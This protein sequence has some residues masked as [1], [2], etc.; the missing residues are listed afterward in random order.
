MDTRVI[1]YLS[2]PFL[3]ELLTDVREAGKMKAASIDIT[4][5]CNLRC[6]GCYFFSDG[7]DRYKSPKDDVLFDQL[8]ETEVNRGTNFLTILGGEPALRPDRLKK[9][10]DNFYRCLVVTN[11]SIRIPYEGLENLVIAISVWGN[12]DRDKDL[13]GNGKIDVFQKG[14]DNFRNDHRAHWYYTCL[15]DNIDEIESVTD[16]IIANGNY[17]GY[18]LYGDITGLGGQYDH[19]KG[20]DRPRSEVERMIR[21]YPD[22]IMNT[23][24]INKI[25]GTGILYDEQWSYDVCSS[26]TFDH[27]A[28]AER[29]ANGHT[30]NRHFRAYNPDFQSTRKC[31]VGEDRDCSN[32]F[33]M[34][35]HM[36]WIMQSM[37]KHTNSK[38]EFT[39]WLV[40]VYVF[41]WI[42]PFVDFE[43]GAQRLKE[44]RERS[45]YLVMDEASKTVS[46]EEKIIAS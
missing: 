15:A 13:R 34:W 16:Q 31:C 41:Y 33:D 30:Y 25:V 4:H 37:H 6:K 2:D 27:P 28:N 19:R 20:F 11:G 45:C 7:L 42:N 5:D 21:K 32:C 23:A 1:E 3:M 38:T 46:A 18:N 10:H 14:L 29:V 43:K 39:H 12:H 40:S 17:M 22:K 26:V 44:I 9:L 35:A 24:Y 36:S 8:I